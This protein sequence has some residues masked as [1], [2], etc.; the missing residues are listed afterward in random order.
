MYPFLNEPQ[1]HFAYKFH[2]AKELASE[3][4]RLGKNK[5]YVDNEKLALRLKFYD[6]DIGKNFDTILIEKKL[7]DDAQIKIKI[8]GATVAAF[9][10]RKKGNL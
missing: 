6:I 2:V 5:I 1:K 7:R 4:K 9:D 8:F 3:L 10:L